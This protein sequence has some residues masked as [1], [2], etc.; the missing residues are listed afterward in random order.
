MMRTILIAIPFLFLISCAPPAVQKDFFECGADNTLV[1]CP[2]GQTPDA[3]TYGD[4]RPVG[5]GDTTLDD[6]VC[7]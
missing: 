1:A 5:D 2:V 6:G 3:A 4:C 7:S